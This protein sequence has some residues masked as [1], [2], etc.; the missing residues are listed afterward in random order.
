M[1]QRGWTPQRIQEAFDNGEQ[2]NA[3]NKA[4]GGAA[5][6]HINPGTGQSVVI[7]S[8]GGEVIHVGGAGFLYGPGSGD[9]P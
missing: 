9:V 5:T 7:Q 1:T 6:R 3:V 2:V 4:T 8:G